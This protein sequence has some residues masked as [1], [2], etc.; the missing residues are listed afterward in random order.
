MSAP[1]TWQEEVA[2]LL[3]QMQREVKSMRE[4]IT[5]IE[6]VLAIGL[7]LVVIVAVAVMLWPR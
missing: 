4:I 5:G 2:L 6:I 1:Q 3:D 7:P